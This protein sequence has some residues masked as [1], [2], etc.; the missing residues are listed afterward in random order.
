MRIAAIR[1]D[2][3]RPFISCPFISASV[4]VDLQEEAGFKRLIM[5]MHPPYIGRLAAS[6]EQ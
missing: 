4:A 2:R 5:Q 6:P 3:Y 1:G